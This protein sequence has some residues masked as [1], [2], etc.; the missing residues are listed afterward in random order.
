MARAPH[1]NT[2]IAVIALVW[3]GLTVWALHRLF[4][5]GLVHSP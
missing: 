4:G 2:A 5:R 1:D 3:F